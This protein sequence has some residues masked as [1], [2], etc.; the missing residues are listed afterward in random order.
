MPQDAFERQAAT[1]EQ[2]PLLSSESSSAKGSIETDSA[3]DSGRPANGNSQDGGTVDR[4]ESNVGA[5]QSLTL[6]RGILSTIGLGGLILLQA[7][8]ISI[9]T[10]TQSAIASDLDAFELTSWFTSA[11]L[12]AMSALGPLNGKFA[13]VFTP[14]ITIFASSVMLA[15]GVV[16]S[17]LASGFRDFIVGRIFAGIGAAGIFTVS[18]IIVLELTGSKRR[19]LAIGMLN[20][21]FT[22]GVAAGATLAG[23]LL[24]YTGWRWLFLGQAPIALIG[25]TC[26]LFSIPRSFT[27]G[28]KAN[29]TSL[30]HSLS[31]L[32]YFGALTLTTSITLCL[33]SLGSSKHI[34]LLPL[35]LSPVALTTFIL[36]ELYLARDP[37]IPITLLKSRGLLFTCLAT[38]G[39]MMA[40]WTVLFYTPTYAIAVRQ[41]SPATAGAILVPTNGGFALGSLL[42]GWLHI[43]RQGSFYVPTLV[44]YA[45]FPPTLILLAV[46]ANHSSSMALFILDVL[47][48]GAA[49]GA[50]L[51]YNLAHLLHLTPKSTHYVATSLL[52]TFRG[53][54]GSFGS[55]IGG[56]LFTRTLHDSL[57]RQFAERGI[58]ND[59][60][61]RRLLGSPALVGQLHGIER[62]IA[63]TA[64]E[65]A[66]R[67]L[68]L[69]G[70]GLAALM[71][72]VQASTGWRKGVEAETSTATESD[73]LAEAENEVVE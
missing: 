27:S 48:C 61:I 26:I 8:N 15:I 32:D 55:A 30:L 62:Q 59:D 23:A 58:R 57:S 10:T 33:Y 22:I 5:N 72:L 11:Y 39:Y 18:I 9:L 31:Q 68:F 13:A 35:L 21:G 51:N 70:A 17:G 69:C 1:T 29:T 41:W 7:T 64:Y 37:I 2:T 52:A 42:V 12:I 54:S 53:F 40:R 45:I 60:L 49:T 14:R 6:G 43:R 47:L 73:S 34:P 50:A 63:V 4:I 28:G 71:I 65:T 19:G 44:V 36:N 46:L 25:G 16:I 66:L 20:T 3:T 38:V 24:P 67:K 56:G